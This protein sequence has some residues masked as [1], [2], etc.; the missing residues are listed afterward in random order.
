MTSCVTRTRR[1]KAIRRVALVAIAIGSLL[2]A[3]CVNLPANSSVNTVQKQV[4]AGSG[5]D[6]SIWPRAPQRGDSPTFAVE[7]FLQN[8]ASGPGNLNIA[9]A[10]LTGEAQK[11]W[12]PNKVLVFSEESS[13]TVISPHVDSN[14]GLEIQITGTVVARLAENGSYQPVSAGQGD[15]TFKFHVSFDKAKG[16]YQIDRMRDD[17]GVALTQESFRAAYAAY[18]LYYLNQDSPDTSMIP[19]PVYLRSQIGDAATAQQLAASLFLGPPNRLNN[20][21]GMAAPQ[22][23][24]DPSTPVTIDSE[25]DATV[26][27]KTPNYC[28]THDKSACSHL[29]D[30][31]LATYSNLGSISRV[32]V[33]DGRGTRLGSSTAV[34]KVMKQY[35]VSVGTSG[36]KSFYYIDATDHRVS[37]YYNG[38][39][40]AAQ[41]GPNSR[42]YS[43]LAITNDPSS[44][45]GQLAAVVDAT[46]TKLYL[47][48]PGN[49]ADGAP[50]WTGTGISS[51]TWDAFGRLWFLAKVNGAAAVFRLDAGH[52][53]SAQPQQVDVIG[54]DDTA[55][56]K[57][58]IAPDGRQLAVDYAEPPSASAPGPLYSVGI[59][60][61]GDSGSPP[62]V[63]LSFALIQPVVS[64]WTNVTGLDWHGSQSLGVLGSSEP[65]SPPAIYELNPDGS[66]VVSLTDPNPVTINP[67]L[68]VS[69]IEW[70]GAMLL[71]SYTSP[72]Q[73]GSGPKLLIDQY[74]FNTSSWNTVS[75]VNG[76]VPS[77]AN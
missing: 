43:L 71:A 51:L 7:G 58:S 77:Y 30:Q 54:A 67:P 68:K 27:V 16:Y 63:N 11:N 19:V 5:A 57:I 1:T 32:T 40:T 72:Q 31:L 29:A 60:V 70:T 18:Y 35:N 15:G 22:I 53:R 69:G 61:V 23:A 26:T 66:P 8:A 47:G 25:N 2:T 52:S 14:G 3:G 38:H 21:A 49:P 39:T 4:K 17:F 34:D 73:P 36:S 20:V 76:T 13:P 46:D 45:G 44:P 75:G 33:A 50:V 10:Y 12:D 37:Q 41:V 6:V 9:Q 64:Q 48:T 59:G 28:T 42:Q 24:L 56:Q 55:V 65:S 62:S 74:A